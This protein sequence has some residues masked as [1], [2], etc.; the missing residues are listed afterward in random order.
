MKILTDNKVLKISGTD[1]TS[2]LQGQLTND[3]AKLD[4]KTAQLNALCQHQGKVIALLTVVKKADDFYAIINNSML[5]IVKNRL[6]MFIIMSDVVIEISEFDAIGCLDGSG[7]FKLNDEISYDL[8]K[9]HDFE[10][11]EMWK[12]TLIESKIPEVYPQTSEK[13]VP[14]MLNL[15][16]DEFGVNFKKGCYTGQEVVARLHYLGTAKRRM[17]EFSSDFEVKV[18]DELLVES[19]TSSKASGIVVSV[20]KLPAYYQFLATLEVDKSYKDVVINNNKVNFK[21]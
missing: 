17:F 20:I 21:G 2:F 11:D 9:D 7:E 3:I 1:A 14:Q 4:E 10:T 18:G 12:T 13:F 8:L 16:I 19:S 15:D 5:D 6:S